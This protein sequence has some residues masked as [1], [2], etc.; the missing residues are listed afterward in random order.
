[1]TEKN[2]TEEELID[3]QQELTPEDQAKAEQEAITAAEHGFNKISGDDAPQEEVEEEEEETQ[4]IV[5]LKAAE[6]AEAEAKKEEAA[7][8]AKQEQLKK[9]M[10]ELPEWKQ[11]VEGTLGDHKDKLSRVIEKAKNVSTDGPTDQEIKAALQNTEA[12]KKLIDEYQEF[13]PVEDELMA[14]RADLS[15]IKPADINKFRDEITET[16]SLTRQEVRQATQEMRELVKLDNKHPDWEATINAQEFREYALEGGPDKSFL[17]KTPDERAAMVEDLARQY[18]KWWG[19]RGAL[20]FSTRAEDTI[21]LLNGFKERQEQ[22]QKAKQDEEKRHKQEKRLQSATT[23]RSMGGRAQPV[24]KTAEQ[25][26]QDAFNR[27]W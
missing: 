18:P 23:P 8:A 12:M 24:D 25:V 22:A 2:T 3:E 9:F 17:D 7:E 26:A 21:T 5:E 15:R 13:K 1:M 19:E 10:D 14:I 20:F 16:V 4:Q 11:R 27:A 6:V